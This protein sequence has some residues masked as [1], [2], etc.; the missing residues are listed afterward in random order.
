VLPVIIFV[1]IAIPLLILAFIG[2]RRSM[3]STEKLAAESGISEAELEREFAAEEA[4][5][6]QLK[7]AQHGH[8]HDGNG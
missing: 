1:C 5:E 6:E 2:I 4:Y 7:K 8:S 3:R